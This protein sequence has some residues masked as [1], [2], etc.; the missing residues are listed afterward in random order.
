MIDI[1]K[2]LFIDVETIPQH[3]HLMK[4][5]EATQ[6]WF[7]SRFL[8][9]TE[10]E[11]EKH[12]DVNGY[13]LSEAALHGEFNKIICISVAFFYI[14]KDGQHANTLCLR[15]KSLF[16]SDEKLTLDRFNMM[17]SEDMFKNYK[18]MAH[19]GKGF[20]YPVIAQ[21]C[22]V[23]YMQPHPKLQTQGKKPWEITDLLDSA[24]LWKHTKWKM[25]SLEALC[26][27]FDIPTPKGDMDGSKVFKEYMEGR[28]HK[29]TDYCED[30][31]IALARSAQRLVLMH[32]IKD[33]YIQRVT[34]HGENVQKH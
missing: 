24:E 17:L 9:M 25:S 7:E 33:E 26:G 16:G 28:L 31:T 5:N 13:Y 20:D 8:K 19:N 15:V 22:L 4:A 12:G 1:Q 11:Q 27:A 32:P 18:L 14:P 2:T 21:R 6:S 10:T 23:N 29:V 34:K 3:D 30:D